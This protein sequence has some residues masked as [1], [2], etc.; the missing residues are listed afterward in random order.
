[1][2]RLALVFLLAFSASA[3][4]HLF[5]KDQMIQYTAKNPY[6]RF[7]DGRPK[8]PDAVLEKMKGL[9]VEEIWK[10]LNSS[11]YQNTYAGDFQQ[12]HSGMKLIGRAVTAQ[13]MPAREDIMEVEDKGASDRGWAK[14]EHQRVIDQLQPGDVLVADLFSKIEG[15]TLVGDNLAAAIH[16]A[17]GNGFVV[18]GAIRDLEGIFPMQ[19]NIYYRGVHPSAVR[20]IM[21]T[22]YNVPV[23]IG[24]AVV[25]PGDI[26]FGDR[27]GVYFVPPHLIE[28]I[29]QTA[30]ETHIH[31]EWTK[32]K[33]S[34]GHYKSTDLY[35]TP[36][37][38]A[39]KK[40][41][42]DYKKKRLR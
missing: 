24:N 18:D 32:D 3:Q 23:R 16:S 33:F 7:A 42:E 19:M 1:M 40:E 22:G 38:P 30:E 36:K 41:Y 37:D 12:L 5:S 11:G 39:L 13:F 20:D 28:K 14:S 25:M 21:L 10:I 9:S 17:T 8:V 35:P 4:V 15:G 29:L 26:V 34:K 31:D 2:S 6:E 27:T